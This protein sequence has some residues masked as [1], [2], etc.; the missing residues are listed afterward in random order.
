LGAKHHRAKLGAPV[1][2]VMVDDQ[3][4]VRAGLRMLRETAAD[5]EVVASAPRGAEA[6]RL[7]ER[8][9]PDVN[10]WICRCREWTASA[11]PP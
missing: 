4:L 1:V 8:T 5:L 10:S 3:Q 11:Q 9:E 7:A 2:I 6:A